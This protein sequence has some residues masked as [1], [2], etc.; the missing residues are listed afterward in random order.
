MFISKIKNFI[1]PSCNEE[2]ICLLIEEIIKLENWLS[3]FLTNR[4]ELVL[5][6]QFK[7]FYPDL[8]FGRNRVVAVSSPGMTTQNPTGSQPKSDKRPVNFYR[9]NSISGTGRHVTAGSRRQRRNRVLIKIHRKQKRPTQYLHDKPD[10]TL[11]SP[12]RL[13]RLN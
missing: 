4:G 8:P 11:H 13:G 5:F 9:F 10:N 12:K 1:V 3:S 2:S 7:L 6:F